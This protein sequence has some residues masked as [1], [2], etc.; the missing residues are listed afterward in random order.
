MD[1]KLYF[2]INLCTEMQA[3]REITLYIYTFDEK[4][5][6]NPFE[7][8]EE[9][10][11]GKI[12]H[13]KYIFTKSEEK[14]FKFY[15][16]L[17]IDIEKKLSKENIKQTIENGCA[18]GDLWLGKYASLRNEAYCKVKNGGLVYPPNE[19]GWNSTKQKMPF[20]W[21]DIFKIRY[22]LVYKEKPL[23]FIFLALMILIISIIIFFLCYSYL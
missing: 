9:D 14:T 15:Y 17:L 21:I 12:K 16:D 10:E 2:N 7:L 5:N 3:G 20:S 8:D 13:I 4:L 22:A 18:Y 11:N 19:R 1:D 6:K 23:F